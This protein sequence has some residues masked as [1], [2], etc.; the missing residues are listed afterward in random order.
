MAGFLKGC[1][2]LPDQPDWQALRTNILQG[3]THLINPDAY[4]DAHKDYDAWLSQ[5]FENVEYEDGLKKETINRL[6]YRGRINTKLYNYNMPEA[7]RYAFSLYIKLI[8]ARVVE[9]LFLL[10]D[11]H[12]IG[13]LAA[14]DAVSNIYRKYQ[15]HLDVDWKFFVDL[16]TL[17]D[18]VP[19]LTPEQ[20]AEL[21]VE[22]IDDDIEHEFADGGFDS[23][24]Y[25]GCIHFLKSGSQTPAID[26]SVDDFLKDPMYWATTGTSDGPRLNLKVGNMNFK[27]R[28]GKW[29]TA[30]ASDLEELKKIF[31]SDAPQTNKAVTKRELGKARI[32]IAGDLPNYLRMSYISK[33]LESRLSRH[34]N[35]TLF[36]NKEQMLT[37]W[38][39][40]IKRVSE[41]MKVSLPIDESKY[42]HYVSKRMIQIMFRAIKDFIKLY[43]PM[44]QKELIAALD[45]TEQS[46]FHKFAN[47]YINTKNGRKIVYW[48]KGLMS[49]WRW[50]ALLNTMANVAKLFAFRTKIQ[51]RLNISGT[52]GDP[53]SYIV[54]QGD[55]VDA[56]TSSL[57]MADA[58]LSMYTETN[59]VV[60]P[61]KLFI[62]LDTDEYLRQLAEQDRI[63]GYPARGISSLCFRN[64]LTAEKAVGEERIRE[65]ASNWL[66]SSR[67][68]GTRQEVVEALMTTD[69]ANANGVPKHLINT[70]IH[71]QSTNGGL[72]LAPLNN[73]VIELIKSRQTR[74]PPQFK[75]SP[76]LSSYPSELQNAIQNIWI[77]GVDFGPKYKKEYTQFSIAVK[78][79]L[80]EPNWQYKNLNISHVSKFEPVMRRDV[81]PSITAAYQATVNEM[82]MQ[83]ILLTANN[84]L[85]PTSVEQLLYLNKTA[86]I[87]VIKSWLTDTLPFHTPEDWKQGPAILAPA[88]R[89]ARNEMMAQVFS[90]SRITRSSIRKAASA[91]EYHAKFF[92]ARAPYTYTN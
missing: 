60:N 71:A 68:C 27:A 18:Y 47:I 55:D 22:W 17:G 83:E 84:W 35:T 21:T 34:P 91:A 59:F 46:L 70:M 9:K 48:R 12:K 76:L 36:F 45:A 1:S 67:R 87:A 19:D 4:I 31:W 26:L 25:Q 14:L 43:E 75:S 78:N 66:L 85:T 49:G 30:C 58:L 32:I 11:R 5:K 64:P 51:N 61:A 50:T 29:A 82:R 90:S 37:L 20:V 16:K 53:L 72:G 52:L 74:P 41:K 3:R 7:T 2:P 28:K 42:D 54:A 73:C 38:T 8:P 62:S 56:E 80:P 13:T 33:W 24:F 81:S 15:K 92:V 88:F 89:E 6:R 77:A 23:L 79:V 86:S 40:M 63:G 39:D 44:Y 69:I 10:L 57:E 65:L